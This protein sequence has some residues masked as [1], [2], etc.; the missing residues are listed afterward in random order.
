M[1]KTKCKKLDKALKK[2]LKDLD[3]NVKLIA[4]LKVPVE[5]KTNIL[6]FIYDPEMVNDELFIFVGEQDGTRH[7]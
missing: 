1:K 2:K 4:K 3:K 6:N 7:H 5:M